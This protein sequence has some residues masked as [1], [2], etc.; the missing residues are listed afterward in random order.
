MVAGFVRFEAEGK[1]KENVR[2]LKYSQTVKMK[3]VTVTEEVHLYWY[4]R[5]Q[6]YE[7]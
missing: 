5:R 7:C 4:R 3:F 1:R 6:V 2:F